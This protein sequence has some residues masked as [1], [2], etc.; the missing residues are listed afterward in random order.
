MPSNV[1]VE[2]EELTAFEEG[3]GLQK[4]TLEERARHMEHF[5]SFYDSECKEAMNVLFESAEGR[6]KFSNILGKFFITLR[7]SLKDGSG[8]GLPKKNYAEKIR[9]SIKVSRMEKEK[10]DIFDIMLFPLSTKRWKAFVTNLVQNNRAETT[11]HEEVSPE[12]M[13]A[14]IELLCNV[15]DALEARGTPEYQSKLNMIPV[16][17]QTKMNYLLQYGAQFVL[18]LFD[19]RRGKEGLEILRK[20]DLVEIEDDLYEFRY[21]R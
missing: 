7:V 21:F 14:I 1:I 6:D 13:E 11:H 19:V 18:T 12:T 3:G 9:S 20:E 4:R 10:Y 5:Q 16:E 15:K 2:E 8:Q 17:W